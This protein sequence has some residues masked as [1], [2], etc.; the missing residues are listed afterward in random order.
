MQE[1]T[2]EAAARLSPFMVEVT[3]ALL[4]NEEIASA[5]D[6]EELGEVVGAAFRRAMSKMAS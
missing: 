3:L 5:M 2:D 6:C 4:D 1:T